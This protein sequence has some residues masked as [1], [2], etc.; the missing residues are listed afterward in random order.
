MEKFTWNQERRE[1]SHVNEYKNEKEIINS[2]NIKRCK[3]LD[4][5]KLNEIKSMEGKL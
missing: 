1:S 3:G 4:L 2:T 5:W